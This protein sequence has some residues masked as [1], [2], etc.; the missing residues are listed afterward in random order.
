MLQKQILTIPLAVGLDQKTDAKQV[1]TTGALNLTN[2]RFFKT[3]KLQKRFGLV[4]LTNS[5]Y[6]DFFN[7]NTNLS[8]NTLFNVVSDDSYISTI[9]NNGVFGLSE[10][11]NQ[12]YKQNGFSISGKVT[13]RYILKNF[14]DQTAVDFDQTSDGTHLAYVAYQKRGTAFKNYLV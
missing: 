3:G 6:K 12:W 4:L 2:V 5:A 9:T 1:P 8:D 10:A 7:Q 11:D 14:F 13:T